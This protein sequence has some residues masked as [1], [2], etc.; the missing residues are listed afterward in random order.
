MYIPTPSGIQT[1]TGRVTVT[2]HPARLPPQGHADTRSQ[3]PLSKHTCPD[4]QQRLPLRLSRPQ[5]H[6]PAPSRRGRARVTMSPKSRLKHQHRTFT[7]PL[8]FRDS[9]H[10]NHNRN[11]AQGW[12]A[13]L[14]GQVGR[15]QPHLPWAWTP[16]AGGL[17]V[18]QRQHQRGGRFPGTGPADPH[19]QPHPPA[20]ACSLQTS[21][22]RPPE[23]ATTR[24]PSAQI[25]EGRDVGVRG[26]LGSQ[27]GC[28]GGRALPHSARC[29]GFGCRWSLVG[30]WAHAPSQEQWAK[31]MRCA[32]AMGTGQGGDLF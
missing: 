17:W 13:A 2:T 28:V 19:P 9:W 22:D 27:A 25:W 23:A 14:G 31:V 11:G 18:G 29:G 26:A 30:L 4:T 1:C 24:L 21:S 5:R 15:H 12:G 8:L 32:L 10:P 7:S 6:A 16:C 20:Q 3:K